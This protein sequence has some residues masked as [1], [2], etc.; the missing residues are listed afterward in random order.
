MRNKNISK[1]FL[2]SLLFVG[3]LALINNLPS[4]AF[5]PSSEPTYQGIDISSWQGDVNFSA[6]KNAGIDIVYIKASE[7]SRYIN[8]YL[9]SSYQNAKANGLKIG[10]YHYVTARTTSEAITQAN[11][12][13]KVIS[14]KSANC[15]LA[16]DFEN[17]GNLSVNQINEISKV[18]LETLEN[19]TGA[20]C[21]IYSNA[22]SARNIFS[23]ELTKYPLWVANYGVSNP[24]PN[25]KW[26]TWVGWQYTSTGT[27]SGVSGYVDRNQFTNGILLSDEMTMP[28][29]EVPTPT[30][31]NTIT[32]TVKRGDTLSAIAR[33]Y[34]TSVA[35][36]VALNPIIKNPNLIYPG[37]KFIIDANDN[38]MEG[39]N[40]CGK[41]LYKI[42]Y[43]DTLS[44][45][46]LDYNSSVQ[47]IAKLNNIANP[48]LIYAGAIIQIPTCYTP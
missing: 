15:R 28:T 7:G 46:A 41:I 24:A 12:F 38:N 6:V 14:N 39:Q 47:G 22:Y 44:Q 29:P 34:N 30:P 2:I 19:T 16:M 21:V 37:Q 11:F 27:V 8:P 26:D 31:A 32:Y 1:K 40:S 3:F 20:Q 17:F 43:G 5:G 18:F 10:F 45:I 42:Q 36:I 13:A 25:G 48:N 35:S 9:E 4:L 33:R 23:R